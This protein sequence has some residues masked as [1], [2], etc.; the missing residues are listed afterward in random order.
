MSTWILTA[1]VTYMA[2]SLAFIPASLWKRLPSL[3][4]SRRH[5]VVTVA[6]AMFG[7]ALFAPILSLYFGIYSLARRLRS[8]EDTTD[9]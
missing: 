8:G 4:R 2:L 3:A 7:T 1:I 6:L 5:G 9:E